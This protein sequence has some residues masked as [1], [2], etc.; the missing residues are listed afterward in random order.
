MS[1]PS[2]VTPPAPRPMT[3]GD[4]ATAA[5]LVLLVV[6]AFANASSVPFLFDDRPA[7]ERNESIRQ[8]WPLTAPLTPPV[9][10]AGVAGRPLTN[11][12]LAINYAAGGLDVRGYHWVNAGLHALAGLALWGLLRRTLLRTQFARR[13]NPLA[14][15]IS[16]L[17]L[18]HPLQTESVVCVVQ[19]N[20]ILVGLFYLL[21]LYAFVRSHETPHPVR[22]RIAMVAACLAGMASKEVMATAPLIVLLYDR[23]FVSGTFRA[24]WTR[25]GRWHLALAG[26]WLLLGW[27]VL[28][29]EQRAGTV[30]FGL[31]VGTWE[32][33]LTQCRALTT[34]LRLALWPHPLVVDYGPDVIRDATAV[35][36]EA[37]IVLGL[38]GSSVFALWRHPR[39]G[40]AAATFFIGL[41]PSSSFLPLTTQPMAEHRM[42]L[43]LAALLTLAAIGAALLLPRRAW[44]IPAAIGLALLGTTI[45]RN[46]DYQSEDRLWRDTI[47]KQP[48][49]A[50]A[51]ASL[52]GVL[53]RRG[54]WSESVPFYEQALRLRPDY[55]DAQ[56]DFATALLQLG[57]VDRAI[58]HYERAAR[59]KPDD[60]DL[61]YNLAQALVRAGRFADAIQMYEAVLARRPDHQDALVGYGDALHRAGRAEE[62]LA[63]FNRALAR[64]PT[65][66]S[67]H[68]N[69]AVALLALGR[70]A[71][72]AR[73]YAAA[74][75]AEPANIDWRLNL[76]DTLLR[77]SQP[78]EAVQA[79]AAAVQLRPDVAELHY[80]L[81]N[82]WLQLNRADEAVAAYTGALKLRPDWGEAHHNLGLAL[83]QQGRP[84]Q[85]IPH[86]DSALRVLPGSAQ[87]HHSLAL[88]LAEVGRKTE[89][90]EHES[91]ALRLD[92]AFEP[93]RRHL[94]QLQQR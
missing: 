22:W 21:T 76:A 8:L 29:H 13:A 40:F 11:L 32:Y 35:V 44:A 75:A 91:A 33:L 60:L 85:A 65:S 70:P 49:N 72:A 79:Y 51:Y 89:A 19:R 53:A 24:A 69:A 74:A 3:I 46:T 71:D 45:R 94:Q 67:L 12:T 57:Q 68:H 77:A 42:Y 50:R 54:A 41:A 28:G 55:A 2:T 84:A 7:I 26:T 59:L 18:V 17:W 83:V 25:N 63:A 36:M 62:A 5:M 93:S 37:A 92:P 78:A 47:A 52:A 16:S 38:L 64:Q 61:R 39:T 81:G 43:P 48:E 58:A 73:H 88:A 23:T 82:I 80:N 20:E 14:A 1:A 10:G 9:T 30:G 34:Y 6:L 66:A 56:S 31:G 87:V 90:V 86:Y 15:V 27:L 4:G